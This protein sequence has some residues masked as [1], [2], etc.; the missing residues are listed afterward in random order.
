MRTIHRIGITV[1]PREPYLAWARSIDDHAASLDVTAEQFTSIYL[2]DA[3][4]AFDS[5]KV[6]RKQFAAIFE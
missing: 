2:V 3:P 6:I 1:T 5:A 4:D